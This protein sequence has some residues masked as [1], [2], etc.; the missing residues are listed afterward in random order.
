MKLKANLDQIRK[1]LSKGLGS[2]TDD[3]KDK[4]DDWLRRSTM[5]DTFIVSITFGDNRIDKDV[6]IGIGMQ[7]MLSNIDCICGT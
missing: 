2:H 4:L 7:S 3:T 1:Y 5:D 6:G